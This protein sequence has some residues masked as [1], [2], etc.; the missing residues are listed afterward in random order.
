MNF[1]RIAC[2]LLAAWL[3]LSGCTPQATEVWHQV[4]GQVQLPDEAT[5]QADTQ[6]VVLLEE[7]GEAHKAP[8]RLAELRQHAQLPM[9]FLLQNLHLNPKAV[10]NYQLR[11][12]IETRG[13]RILWRSAQAQPLTTENAP[14]TL[15]LKAVAPQTP[16]TLFFKCDDE[17]LRLRIDGEQ[18][19]LSLAEH[20]YLLTRIA[21][22]SGTHYQ[23]EA[24]DFWTKGDEA[25]LT[26][27]GQP[28]RHCSAE[29]LVSPWAE[30]A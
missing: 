6:L 10:A 1:L 24:A 27:V 19:T 16:I 17:G 23:S 29:P 8:A 18:A 25:I 7:R 4:S 12:H 30:A 2:A 15:T 20:T 22:A 3:W 11:A 9:H 5:L 26:L 28:Q 21:S 13:G 14:V